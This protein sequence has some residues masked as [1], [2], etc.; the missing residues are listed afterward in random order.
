MDRIAELR[1][2]ANKIERRREEL[3]LSKNA[4]CLKFGQLG[5]TKTFGR[6]L[7]D[8]DDLG[9]LD[10]EAQL[11]NYRAA[12]ELVLAFD[13]DPEESKIYSDFEFFQTAMD[14]VLEA[15]EESDNTRLVLIT[16]GS[17]GGKST[18]LDW[19]CDY[20][21]TRGIC[22]PVEATE[23]W[24]QRESGLLNAWLMALGRYDGS[25][26]PRHQRNEFYRSLPVGSD[27][28]LR[29][30]TKL[31]DGKRLILP[32]DEFHHLGPAGMNVVKTVLNQTSAVVVGA[33]IPELMNRINKTSHEETK[34]LF[35]N[36]LY[37][38]VDFPAPS[39]GDV[40]EYLKRRGVK[41]T[42]PRDA[43][44]VAEKL[45]I[46]ARYCGLW[47]FVKRCAKE[48]KRREKKTTGLHWGADGFAKII[49]AV[50]SSISLG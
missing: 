31:I 33:T 11:E 6:I 9:Q 23:A 41:F 25:D 24:R 3:G 1:E 18:F 47:K 22:F 44:A 19:L 36:R 7:N 29:E 49:G 48:A 8:K 46:D 50:K 12:L 16:A 42:G 40:L 14:A 2:L 21:L 43:S 20:K 30:L 17:G 10:L 27:A 26:A 28:K 4:L 39:S 35:H 34:Q 32:I 13:E 5:S 37:K 15:R 45:S 38:R